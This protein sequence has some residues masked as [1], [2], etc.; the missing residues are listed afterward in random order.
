MVI[1]SGGDQARVEEM[2]EKL[3]EIC[4]NDEKTCSFGAEI[5]R[6]RVETHTLRL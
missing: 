4:N 6:I 2:E 3:T 5:S 1:I